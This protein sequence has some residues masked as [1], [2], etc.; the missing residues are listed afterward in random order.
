MPALK[1]VAYPEK[2]SGYQRA[3]LEYLCAG[4]HGT[5]QQLADW[6]YAHRADG[7]PLTAEQTVGVMLHRI[8]RKLRPGWRIEPLGIGL[9]G[10]D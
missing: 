6:L 2:L 5:N 1:D 9:K 10:P 7:G 8:R 4:G 3:L